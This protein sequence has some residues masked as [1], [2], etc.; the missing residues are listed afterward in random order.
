MA[1]PEECHRDDAREKGMQERRQRLDRR[2]RDYGPP[3]G[4]NDRRKQPERRLPATE[5]VEMS[6]DE[7]ARWFGAAAPQPVPMR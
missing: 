6:A 4:W 3:K 7:F 5:D 1:A 2:V